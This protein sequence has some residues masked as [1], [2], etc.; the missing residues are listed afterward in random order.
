M[1]EIISKTLGGLS[2][3]Y[4]ARN[5]FFGLIFPAL[6]ITPAIQSGRGIEFG[7]IIF[8]LVN[9]LLYPYSRF[10]YESITGFILGNNVFFVNAFVMLFFKL[11]TMALC[12]AF[13]IF[14]APLGL[15]YLYFYHSKSTS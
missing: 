13:A 12:W 10:V 1:H 14:V 4:Y 5:L 15:A 2:P 6:I 3:R 9:T 11:L 8:A 7:L